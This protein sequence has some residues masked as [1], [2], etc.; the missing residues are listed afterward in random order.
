M[1]KTTGEYVIKANIHNK[2]KELF[3]LFVSLILV[4]FVALFD[5]DTFREVIPAESAM[6]NFVDNILLPIGKVGS[7]ILIPIILLCLVVCL[8]NISSRRNLLYINEKGFEV[9]IAKQA[10]GFIEWRDV[11]CM[12]VKQFF[13]AR[14]YGITLK[15]PEKYNIRKNS[16]D[17][18]ILFTSQYFNNQAD[19]VE[20]IIKFHIENNDSSTHSE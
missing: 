9:N 11:E 1:V 2:V 4:G 16:N 7:W 12:T 8:K 6:D 13:N 19:E 5:V 20:A 18:H 15:T 17:G 14:A 10:T 3:M